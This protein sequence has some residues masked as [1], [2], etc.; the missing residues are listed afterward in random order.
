M[1]PQRRKFD[2]E[3]REGAVRIVKETGQRGDTHCT[4]ASWAFMDSYG[5]FQ[6]RL[7]TGSLHCPGN[8]CLRSVGSAAPHYPLVGLAGYG[9]DTLEVGVVVEHG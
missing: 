2:P 8:R 6:L 9:G 5:W 4:V 1:S 7:P 3:F